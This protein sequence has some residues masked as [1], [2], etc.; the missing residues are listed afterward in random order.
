MKKNLRT[1]LIMLL[2][3]ALLGG[4]AAA[5][6]LT[7]P[8]EEE[9]EESSSSQVR[10]ALLGL[11]PEEVSSVKVKN[12]FGEFTLKPLS[13][14]EAEEEESSSEGESGASSSSD[15]DEDAHAVLFTLEEYRDYDPDTLEITEDVE[16][17]L[18]LE[19]SKELGAVEDLEPYGLSGEEAD[20]FVIQLTD[21][22][23][24]E[25]SVGTQAGETVGNY[26][27][28]EGQVTICSLDTGLLANPLD[29]LG[30]S[31]YTVED[32]EDGSGSD[33]ALEDILYYAQITTE[34][35]EEILLQYDEME[36]AYLLGEPVRAQMGD[37]AGSTLATALKSLTASGVAAAGLSQE[38]LEAYG[39]SQPAAQVTF[40]MNE[41]VH[42]LQVSAPDEEGSRYLLFDTRELIYK[43]TSSSV[44]SWAAAQ[45]MDLRSGAV[46]QPPIEDVSALTFTVEGDQVYQYTVARTQDEASS[47]EGSASYTYAVEDP[48]GAEVAY[49][50]YEALFDQA[51]GISV[52]SMDPAEQGAEAELTV[53][54]EDFSGGEGEEIAYY[55]VE[56][57]DRYAAYLNGEYSGLV[58]ASDVAG[59]I[60]ALEGDA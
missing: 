46:W 59:L 2:V 14:E 38:N 5:L 23:S 13:Q 3:L 33:T 45:V 20:R 15:V 28:Y 47:T 60:E 54:M 53:E 57:Q 10:E 37:S 35:G 22:E 52:L 44:E 43:V 19:V 24:V 7:Q 18:G 11:A 1:F 51:A 29:Y 55:A 48:S 8:Q 50:D 16:A 41:E 6:L 21:G 49:E 42:T 9:A 30:T 32:R 39:L 36:G 12:S 31:V 56:G 25:L 58:R 40:H 26:V 17:L 4:G 27:L 34:A